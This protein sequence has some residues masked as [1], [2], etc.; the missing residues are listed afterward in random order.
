MG[1]YLDIYMTILKKDLFRVNDTML[2]NYY[3]KII[4]Q[5]QEF[6]EIQS[7]TKSSDKEGYNRYFYFFHLD[8]WF[9][10]LKKVIFG[11]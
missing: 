7:C 1:L 10:I 9:Q 8:C 5:D 3:K 11:E 2:C 6:K 4:E